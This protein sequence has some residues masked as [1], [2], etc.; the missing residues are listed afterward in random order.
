[1]QDTKK[2]NAGIAIGQHRRAITNLETSIA[3]KAVDTTVYE[4]LRAYDFGADRA[5]RAPADSVGRDE[6]IR[7]MLAIKLNAGNPEKVYR[8]ATDAL[9]ANGG[10][11]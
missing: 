2:L 10:N 6:F 7:T 1:M 9:A 4:L 8:L 5:A 3:A 11:K